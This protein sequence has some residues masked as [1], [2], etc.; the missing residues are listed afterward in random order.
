[1]GVEEQTCALSG[2][3][4]LQRQIVC[5]RTF[6]A[7]AKKM[8]VEHQ[9]ARARSMVYPVCCHV[10]NASKLPK[11]CKLH[12][13]A[14]ELDRQKAKYVKSSYHSMILSCCCC[15]KPAC[16]TIFRFIDFYPKIIYHFLPPE[17]IFYPMEMILSLNLGNFIYSSV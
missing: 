15:L 2:R 6:D 5:Y 3:R 1:M 16:L 10:S 17:N 9:V 11:T 13:G 12:S 4:N 7:G 8:D 14:D